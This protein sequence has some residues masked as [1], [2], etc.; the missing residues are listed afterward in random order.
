MLPGLDLS[1]VSAGSVHCRALTPFTYP[2]KARPC[3]FFARERALRKSCDLHDFS[4]DLYSLSEELLRGQ[5]C[6]LFFLRV[7]DH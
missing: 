7:V 3:I 4:S 6:L 5:L 2:F 1:Q